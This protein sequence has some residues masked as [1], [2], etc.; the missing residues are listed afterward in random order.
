MKEIYIKTV[1]YS[2]SAINPLIEQIDDTVEKRA[3]NSLGDNSPAIEQCNRIVNLTVQKGIL[4]E[5]REVM[6]KALRSFDDYEMKCLQYKY[7]KNKPKKYFADFD[8]TNRTYFRTQKK[9]IEY[10][11]ALFGAMGV[12]DEYFEKY[13]LLVPFIKEVYRRVKRSED[14]IKA[15]EI[16]KRR[17]ETVKLFYKPKGVRPSIEGSRFE[18]KKNVV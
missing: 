6:R 8:A 1:L 15:N 2:A 4:F 11:S 14:M 18:R 9:I 7:F 13:L 16:K 3:V 12:N 17:E 10:L 5:L